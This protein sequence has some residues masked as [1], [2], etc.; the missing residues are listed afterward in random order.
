MEIVQ[1][2]YE[3]YIDHVA[4]KVRVG[5]VAT[6][7]TWRKLNAAGLVSV[8]GTR[9]GSLEACFASVRKHRERFGNAPI[10]INL[11]KGNMADD[12]KVAGK[13]VG[14]AA[15]GRD[16]SVTNRPLHQDRAD[17]GQIG[18]WIRPRRSPA[19]R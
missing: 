5:S 12:P 16:T 3:V 2:R 8:Q 10:T 19:L 7:W 14:L 15:A 18:D 17:L 9:H 13:V 11:L 6:H 4:D 1:Q